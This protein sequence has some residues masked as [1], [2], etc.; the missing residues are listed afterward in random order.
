[1]AA[2]PMTCSYCRREYRAAAPDSCIGCGAPLLE[3][4]LSREEL[5][6]RLNLQMDLNYALLHPTKVTYIAGW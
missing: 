2:S 4:K 3:R 1:M 6:R 5:E